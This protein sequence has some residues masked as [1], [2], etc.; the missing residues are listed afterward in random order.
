MKA[1]SEDYNIPSIE[2]WRDGA[3]FAETKLQDTIDCMDECRESIESLMEA[4]RTCGDWP[5]KGC[6][7]FEDFERKG[8]SDEEI[9]A[10]AADVL[11]KWSSARALIDQ[12]RNLMNQART[13]MKEINPDR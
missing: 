2:G 7:Y 3:G 10:V 4:A 13:I 1:G 6:P 8:E 11:D 5:K 12:A 9:H